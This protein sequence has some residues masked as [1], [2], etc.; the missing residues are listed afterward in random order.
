M[1]YAQNLWAK[2]VAQ[3]TER[4]CQC[5]TGADCER[6]LV[7]EC[8]PHPFPGHELSLCLR[9]ALEVSIAHLRKPRLKPPIKSMP[10][11]ESCSGSASR[12]K[13]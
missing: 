11:D 7:H 2:M 10:R 3:A 12:K 5:E 9:C 1:S 4:K 6:C 13:T 8:E